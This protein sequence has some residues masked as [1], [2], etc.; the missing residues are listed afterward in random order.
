MCTF[1]FRLEVIMRTYTRLSWCERL[2]IEALYNAGHSYAFIARQLGRSTSSI[3]LDIQH[4]LY[5]HMGAETS[6][7]PCRYS[8]VRAQDYARYQATAKGSPLKM[9]FN[10]CFA[11][12]VRDMI[13]SGRSIEHIVNY[14]KSHGQFTV[15]VSTLYRYVDRG[16]IPDVTNK[17]LPCRGTHKRKKASVRLSRLPHGALITDRP[18]L[19][20]DR[21][22][23]GH[24]EMDSV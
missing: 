16:F 12:D 7:R 11:Y 1:K 18:F 6:R 3:Y 21:S 8:A 14:K 10:F 19:P 4:G 20:D 15:S 5:E 13:F 2:Q 22:E 9:G 23:F 24:W 17:D